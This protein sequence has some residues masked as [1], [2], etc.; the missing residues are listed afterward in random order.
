MKKLLV[1]F[2]IF[3]AILFAT[4]AFAQTEWPDRSGTKGAVV[5]GRAVKDVPTVIPKADFSLVLNNLSG[6]FG[7]IYGSGAKVGVA[8]GLGLDILTYK[9][10]LVTLRAQ[11]FFAS[12][13]VLGAE[14]ATVVGTAVLVNLIKVSGLVPGTSWLAKAINPSIGLFGGYDFNSGRLVGG[15]MVSIINIQF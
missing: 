4:S 15:P 14:N 5:K 13:D 12:T 6:D 7:V 1:L 2:S 3:V 8:P 10:G 11:A 9:E